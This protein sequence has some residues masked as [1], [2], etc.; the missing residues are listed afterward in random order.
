MVVTRISVYSKPWLIWHLCNPFHCV[1]QRL[2]FSFPFEAFFPHFF[3]ISLPV[4]VRLNRFH[5]SDTLSILTE[6]FFYVFAL[7]NPKLCLFRLKISLPLQVRL[8]RFHCMCCFLCGR[9]WLYKQVCS[10]VTKYL[11]VLILMLV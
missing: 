1:I 5:W 7:C 10:Y 8:D 6:T 4:H 3:W 9:W 11:A 2:K